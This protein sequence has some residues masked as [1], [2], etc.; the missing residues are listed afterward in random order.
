MNQERDAFAGSMFRRLFAPAVISSVGLA[1]SDMADAIVVG[2][3]MGEVGLAAIGMSLPLYM[4]LNI[5]MHGFGI[6]GSVRYAKLL[7]EGDRE[8]AVLSFNRVLRAS[9]ALSLLIAL[10]INLFPAL[11]LR[12]MG[13]SAEDGALYGATLSYV[14]II[15]LG[16]PLFF[17]N[18]ILN[19]YLR[20]DDS[21]K[22]AS[23]G[24]LAGNLTD[25]ALNILFVV[26]LDYGTAGAACA[27]LIGLAVSLLCYLPALLSK[28]HFL[29]ICFRYIRP[30]WKNTFALFRSGFSTS[31]QYLWQ[32]IFL[33]IANHT[34]IL[35][36]GG[37]GVAVFDMV[38]NVSYL[39]MYLYDAA[40]KA[41]QPLAST[42]CGEKNRSAALHSRRIALFC[43]LS[44]G[45]IAILFISLFPE[46]VCT[47]FGLAEPDARLLAIRALRI[48]CLG[49]SFAGVSV[50]LESYYQSVDEERCAFAISLLRG[51][52]TLIP[53]T[54]L[55]GIFAPQA[56]WYVF[57]I[58]EI[59]SF[60]FF[61]GWKKVFYVPAQKS[62]LSR[63]F[64]R[65][66]RS[67]TDD[68][69]ALTE[70]IS[71]FCDR[72]GASARQKYFVTMAAE[73]I[74]LAIIDGGFVGRKDGVIQLTLIALENG[75]FELHI[76]DNATSFDPFS[77]HTDK[78]GRDDFDMDA[79][80]I[81][82]I[83][84]RA[85]NFFYRRYQGF[86]SLVVR[87]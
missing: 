19:Y 31:S 78:V 77:L 35:H 14:R 71:D 55:L 67:R 44:V 12:L 56:F 26:I 65:A 59:L 43:G 76:R 61:L 40:S 50:I 3:R 37:V 28:K 64:S 6:G 45:L 10:A 11:F 39:V 51:C 62:D 52:V 63:V 20:N 53:A 70:D 72:F 46:S 30:E 5:C 58:A 85:K 9:L 17:L 87:I 83:K 69:G 80:G 75:E 21:A 13:T 57:P 33:L 2:R 38:Q 25:I 81:L 4:A 1:L 29:K 15:A 42:F 73:E 7:G 32:M 23:L 54:L 84:K 41:L 66:I 74:S 49:A 16:A 27:T 48:Y 8:G 34:L 82:V 79:M 47:I 60:V 24:F 86:N 18:Y 36:L 68:L 22:A